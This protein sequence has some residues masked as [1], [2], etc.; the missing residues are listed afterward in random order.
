MHCPEIAKELSAPKQLEDGYM[1][2]VA[3]EPG[4]PARP[5]TRSYM[6]TRAAT[7]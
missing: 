4:R 2:A 5:L 3:D 6:T 7:G 1:S